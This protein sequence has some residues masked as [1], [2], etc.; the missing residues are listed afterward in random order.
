MENLTEKLLNIRSISLEDGIELLEEVKQLSCMKCKEVIG[1]T[2]CSLGFGDEKDLF[3]PDKAVGGLITLST[4]K[5]RQRQK[6]KKA[7]DVVPEAE[8]ET[9]KRPYNKRS[10]AVAKSQQSPKKQVKKEPLTRKKEPSSPKKE[11]LLPKKEPPSKPNTTGF[12]IIECAPNMGGLSYSNEDV[13]IKSMKR[14]IV[15]QKTNP[16]KTKV[17]RNLQRKN[18]QPFVDDPFV[19]VSI[20]TEEKFVM[21]CPCMK[22]NCNGLHPE[23]FLI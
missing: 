6:G 18:K 13:K 16:V 5:V 15:P 4:S 1:R 11:P 23:N 22:L 17:R 20:V 9:K 8:G 2:L 3:I 10:Q 12:S 7:E 21:E 14:K 19:D